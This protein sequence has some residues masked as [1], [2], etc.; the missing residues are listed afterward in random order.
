MY[1]TLGN[2]YGMLDNIVCKTNMIFSMRSFYKGAASEDYFQAMFKLSSASSL[3]FPSVI[4]L[5]SKIHG[6]HY[7]F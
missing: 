6:D 7:L 5:L 3:L 4:S 2:I 1:D